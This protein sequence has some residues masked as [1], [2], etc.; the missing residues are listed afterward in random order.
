MIRAKI[1]AMPGNPAGERVG[2]ST[3][4]WKVVIY[5]Y[6]SG[7]V[8]DPL[9]PGNVYRENLT[10][11]EARDLSAELERNLNKRD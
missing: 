3:G 10:F 6:G 4:F 7:S 9:T 5:D 2:V 8:I 11:E 1:E